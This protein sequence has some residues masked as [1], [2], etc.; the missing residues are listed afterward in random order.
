MTPLIDIGHQL[1][2]RRRA[3]GVSQR[4]LGRFIVEG[5]GTAQET[6]DNIA[7]EYD[8]ILRETGYIK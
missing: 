3:L 5:T 1:V 8:K 6:M 2:E 7:T 4:E